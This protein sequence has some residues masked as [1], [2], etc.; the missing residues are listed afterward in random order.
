MR[1]ILQRRFGGP[2]ALELEQ[3]PLPEPGRGELR[4]RV[5]AAALNPKDVLIRKG[6][7]ALLSGRRFPLGTG[8]DVT[9]EIDA[10]GAN[11]TEFRVGQRVFGFMN[12]F[13]GGTCADFV[14]LSAKWCAPAPPELSPPEAAALP[15][16]ASTAL[17]ALRD[18]GQVT[19]GTR[20]LMHGAAGGLGLHA[21]QIARALGAHVTTTSSAASVARCR[22]WGADE[23]LTYDDP[24]APFAS[25]VRYDVILDVYGNRNFAWAASG[26]GA[27]GTY[28]T[29]VPSRRIVIDTL[30]TLGRRPRARLVRVQARRSD[31]EL[32]ARM[33][34]E[35]TLRP[36]IDQVLPLE[37]V[38]DGHRYL[39]SRHAKGKLVIEVAAPR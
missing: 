5:L 34:A 7:F 30:R 38:A 11:V 26:L 16:V 21:I 14:A 4:L 13:R 29:T 9:G 36:V 10:I 20:V 28:V 39:E 27:A 33:V 23:T 12:R 2:E 31:L 22:Q 17:Q 32:V 35:G 6:R 1:A 19:R 37:R 18:L 24:A 15:L 8:L 25:G 3:A